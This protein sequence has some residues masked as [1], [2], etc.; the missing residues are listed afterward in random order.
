M[1]VW[2]RGNSAGSNW[3]PGLLD[4]VESFTESYVTLT[5]SGSSAANGSLEATYGP[6][7]KN[8]GNF[9]EGQS[10]SVTWTR[11][12]TYVSTIT[13]TG[14]DLGIS[15][16]DVDGQSVGNGGTMDVSEFSGEC[17]ITATTGTNPETYPQ[18]QSPTLDLSGGPSQA[19][20]LVELVDHDDVAEWDSVYY[21]ATT[22]AG[23]V[24]VYAVDPADGSRL[25]GALDDPGDISDISNNLN[26]AFEVVFN[27]TSTGTLTCD[28]LYRRRKIT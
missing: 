2:G 27:R 18:S 16:V 9:D 22:D 11:D 13:V 5:H 25:T 28:A 17:D 21:Q 14:D 24:E 6:E 4:R 15:N 23:A 10:G 1:G 12:L 8:T 19:S 26:V 3:S 20:T 7:S